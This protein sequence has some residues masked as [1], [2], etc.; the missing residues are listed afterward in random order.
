MLYGVPVLE[1][2]P[3]V[4]GRSVLVRCDFNVP[5]RDG[6]IADD[7]RIRAALPTLEWLTSRGAKVTAVTHLGRPE[8]KPDP[9]FD[10]APVRRRPVSY[11]HLTLPTSDLV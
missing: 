1:D 2:L 9:A 6:E 7:H 5:L 10:V 4:D 11:T 8:G 3:S